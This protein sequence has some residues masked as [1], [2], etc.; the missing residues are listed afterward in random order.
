MLSCKALARLLA[1]SED[2]EVVRTCANVLERE[3][4]T[5]DL[6]ASQTPTEEELLVYFAAQADRY[7]LAALTTFTH[8]FVDP[9]LRGD[10]VFV[11]AEALGARLRALEPPTQV[12][13]DDHV[14]GSRGRVGNTQ[15]AGQLAPRAGDRNRT[16]SRRDRAAL[17]AAHR[18]FTR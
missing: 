5:E 2:E 8:V 17:H 16:P 1:S 14:P 10:Q 18:Q 9:D 12:V 6:A 13:R 7:E 11:H 15:H 3:F 4:L